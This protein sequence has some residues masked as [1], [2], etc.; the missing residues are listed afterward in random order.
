MKRK[1]YLKM[2]SPE[3]ARED[4]LKRFP[5]GGD[6][7][8]EEIDSVDA[9][10]RVTGRPVFA[11][12]SSPS[13][14]AAAMDGYAV[15]AEK[16]FGA[17]VDRPLELKAGVDAF[18][19]NTGQPL[20]EG[21]NAV[22][23]VEDVVDID[24]QTIA[25]ESPS[26][27][28]QHVRRV[29]EDIVATELLI[30]QNHRLTPFDLGALLGAGMPRVAVRPKPKVI[31]I[32]T[33]SELVSAGDLGDSSPA[34]GRIIEYNTVVL[35][36]MIRE[37]GGEPIRRAIVPDDFIK[38]K[39]A[40][41]QAILQD[42]DIVVVVNAGSSAGT[43]DHT[44]HVIEDLG[45]VVAHG[46]SMM[47]GKPTIL[48][49][50]GKVA[51]I[52]NP[53]YPVSAIVSCEQ[54]LGPLVSKLLG[55]APPRRSSVKAKTSRKIPSKIGMEEFI[56]V[57]LGD[58]GGNIIATPM[59]R[60]AGS[61]TTMTQADGILRIG[62]SVEG[63][64]DGEEIDVELLR[65]IEAVKKTLVAIGSHDLLPGL[66]GGPPSGLGRGIRTVVPATSAAW[67]GSWPSGKD[68]RTLRDRICWTPDTGEYNYSYLKRYLPD[69]PV[70][71]AHLTYREQ[72][73][74]V[75]KGNPLGIQGLDDL[76]REDVLFINR[77]GGSGTRVLLD[78]HLK[79]RNLDPAAIR[80]YETEEYTHMAVA[81]AVK[82][83]AADAGAG[84]FGRG[85]GLWISISSPSRRSATTW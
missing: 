11:R 4:F 69:P 61:I 34:P 62:E 5:V 30:P 13:Y 1:V 57:Q 35:A 75:A 68:T 79:D 39:A 29:G 52:G 64:L 66:A 50:V 78:Y 23:M 42:A 80:G 24:E 22:V 25:I 55:L 67:A 56:R 59:P 16:T 77:Q 15:K 48:G 7:E 17:H 82:S 2:R 44:V 49:V 70:R 6:R 12:L 40:V 46:I 53:G 51:V 73:F 76:V 31:L 58:V 85:E 65:P 54:F 20:P 84:H 28:W 32:P 63:L 36:E 60:A 33:G 10:G 72:G 45:E 43:E 3:D 81:V 9:C 14:H 83:G 41:E 26:Y 71:L 37:W 8:P 27:P 18:A 21:T 74:I 19:V 38:I 47:P